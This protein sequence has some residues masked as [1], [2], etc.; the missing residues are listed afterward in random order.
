MTTFYPDEVYI[1]GVNQSQITA[2]FYFDDLDNSMK[3]WCEVR[4]E[5]EKEGWIEKKNIEMI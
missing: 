2:Y 5:D 3:N 4:Y 1:N